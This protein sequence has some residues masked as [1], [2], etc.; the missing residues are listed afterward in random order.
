MEVVQPAAN[1]TLGPVSA[2]LVL[3][4][5]AAVNLPLKAVVMGTVGQEVYTSSAILEMT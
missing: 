1:G 5:D 2:T 4:L 3:A